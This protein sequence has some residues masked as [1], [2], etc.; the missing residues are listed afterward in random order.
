MLNIYMNIFLKVINK[1]EDS[2][3]TYE[4]ITYNKF[5]EY[6]NIKNVLKNYGN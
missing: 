5:I 4:T 1:L 2:L 3:P 6:T